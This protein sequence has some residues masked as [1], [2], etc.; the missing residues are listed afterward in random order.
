MLIRFKE[1]GSERKPLAQAIETAT[2]RKAKYCMAGEMRYAYDFGDGLE[3]HLDGTLKG[4]DRDLVTALK[5]A[6]FTPETEEWDEPKPQKRKGIMDIIVE[7]CN[8]NGVECERLHS[9][10]QMECGDGRWRN[11]DGTF[12]QTT[13]AQGET[14][15]T[16]TIEIPFTS[17]GDLTKATENLKNL[18]SGKA[19]LIKQALG[20]DGTG[21]LPIEITATSVKF[22]WLRLGT[23]P[24]VIEAWAAF[25]AACVKTAKK[26]QRFNATDTGLPENEKFAFRTFLVKISLNN[27]ENKYNRKV[28]LRYLSGDSAFA[29]PESKAKWVAKHGS[30]GQKDAAQNADTE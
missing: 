23:K 3:L 1:Q 10:P 5:T 26:G 11:L 16:I 27:I 13:N 29:T 15:D 17:S 14:A 20:E 4:A 21:E 19:S 18:I 24:G 30:K 28:L 7:H 9:A 2:G 8:E 22:E 6:G 25:L 12:T